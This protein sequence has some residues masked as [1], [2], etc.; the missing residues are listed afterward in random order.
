MSSVQKKSTIGNTGSPVKEQS[1]A[2]GGNYLYSSSS[3]I[4][5]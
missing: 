5:L 3:H 1:A 4:S 2:K